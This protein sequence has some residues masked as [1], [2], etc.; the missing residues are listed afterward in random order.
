MNRGNT[1]LRLFEAILGTLQKNR[2]DVLSLYV[3]KALLNRLSGNKITLSPV[4]FIRYDNN[5][6]KLLCPQWA[7]TVNPNS[8][9]A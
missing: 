2:V 9:I 1:F 4:I 6:H 7:K 5:F 3:F 8:T